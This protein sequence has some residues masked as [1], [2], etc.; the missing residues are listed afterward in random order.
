[1]HYLV[2][3]DLEIGIRFGWGLNEQTS[4]FFSNAWFGWRY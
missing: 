4:S 3:S 1:M 2:T